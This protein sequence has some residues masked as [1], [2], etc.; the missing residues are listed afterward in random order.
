MQKR[1][2]IIPF[3]VWGNAWITMWK[4]LR[5]QWMSGA[6]AASIH[7]ASL[8]RSPVCFLL[9]RTLS[10]ASAWEFF[11]F[12]FLFS[13][14]SNLRY[15]L[16]LMCQISM[17][18]QKQTKKRTLRNHTVRGARKFSTFCFLGR[19]YFTVIGRQTRSRWNIFARGVHR[20]AAE[21]TLTRGATTALCSSPNS[22]R[23]NFFD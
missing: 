15:L 10:W 23:G 9:K 17:A 13:A 5:W 16:R 11:F 3:P 20:V 14:L 22:S 6:V 2:F 21:A 8:H 18:T 4:F 7:P 19:K 12:F 1:F